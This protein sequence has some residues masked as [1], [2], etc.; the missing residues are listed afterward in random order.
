MC[1]GVPGKILNIENPD[2]I[3]RHGKVEIGKIVK[4]ISLA[5][6]P[7]AQTGD[8][9]IVHAGFAISIIDEDEAGAMLKAVSILEEATFMKE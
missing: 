7:D 9:V 5:F 4:D 8:Y 2:P 1:L 3:Y 6:V